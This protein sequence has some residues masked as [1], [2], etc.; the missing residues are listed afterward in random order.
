MT[1][2][3]RCIGA[4]ACTGLLAGLVTAAPAGAQPAP[5]RESTGFLDN[6]VTAHRGYSSAYPE[7]TMRAFTEALELGVDW[8]ELDVFTTAD[9]QVVVA[10]DATTGRFADRDLR[11]A[12]HTYAEL[13][14]LDVAYG[15]R[16]AN[17]LTKKEVP[18]AR[19]PLLS[20]ALELIRSQDRTRVSIQPKDGSTAAAVAMVQELG[21]Q[22]WVGFNDGNLAKMSLVK[23]LD[24]SIHVFWDLP[25]SGDIA[26]EMAIARDRGFESLIVNQARIS[27]E[28]IATIEAGGFE[29]GAW[30]VNDTEVMRRFIGWGIDRLYTDSVDQ[31]LLLF[32]H[33]PREGLGRGLLGH[34]AFDEGRG[35]VADDDGSPNPLRNGRLRADAD[36][37]PPGHGHLRGAVELDGH[38]D[39]VDVPFQVLPDQAPAYT[40]SAWFRP[41]QPGRG[42]QFILETAGSWAVSVELADVSGHL[43]YSVQTDGTSVVAES[44]IT[45]AAGRWHHV[46]VSYDAATG[47]SRL[48]LDG[49]EVTSF[50]DP[51]ETGSGALADTTG[52]HIGTYRGADGRFFS[53]AIDDVAVWNRVLDA[54]ELATLWNDG[55]GAAVPGDFTEPRHTPGSW[56]PRG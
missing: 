47:V 11:I 15:F 33:D 54:D 20:E 46:A 22:A 29:S 28:L 30:T 25:A 55:D 6:G 7:N 34:W 18:P 42:R 40:A 14:T 13:S 35:S 8:I 9:G 5:S 49:A 48:Y 4:L 45:P 21:A 53:G 19:M 41:E 44:G 39:H 16:A 51:K 1:T 31:A 32:G 27:P 38:G 24:P 36:L 37:T 3:H 26:A 12:D 10:H 56:S 43:K 17:G 2:L 50:A 52:L 23:E